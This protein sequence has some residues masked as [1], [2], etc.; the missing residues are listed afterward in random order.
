[1]HYSGVE[2]VRLDIYG[3]PLAD[4]REPKLITV[5]NDSREQWCWLG[6]DYS[7]LG[8]AGPVQA[9][10]GIRFCDV[11]DAILPAAHLRPNFVCVDFYATRLTAAGC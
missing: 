1:V 8:Y 10:Q 5:D 6:R 9:D 11:K 2:K 7:E 4:K 3:S